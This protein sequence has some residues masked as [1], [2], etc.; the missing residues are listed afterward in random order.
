MRC[1]GVKVGDVTVL[2]EDQPKELHS[3]AV[4]SD[5]FVRSLLMYWTTCDILILSA[6]V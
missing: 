3:G 5:D 6:D 2:P 1:T 4:P